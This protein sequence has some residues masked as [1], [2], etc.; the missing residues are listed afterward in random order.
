MVFNL[1]DSILNFVMDSFK[2]GIPIP[3]TGELTTYTRSARCSA[4]R[5]SHLTHIG[6]T[7]VTPSPLWFLT[8]LLNFTVRFTKLHPD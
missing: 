5:A 3:Q 1:H 4:L 8:V 7:I 6:Q 2:L